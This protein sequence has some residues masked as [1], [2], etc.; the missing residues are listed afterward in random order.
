MKSADEELCPRD[1]IPV[2]QLRSLSAFPP[3]C[4]IAVIHAAVNSGSL[5]GSQSIVAARDVGSDD[6][7]LLPEPDCN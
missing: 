5:S 1:S 7:T 4:S 6:E 3:R 2:R